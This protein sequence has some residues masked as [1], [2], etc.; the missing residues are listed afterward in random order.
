[1][2]RSGINRFR[3]LTLRE[4]A[5]GAGRSAAAVLVIAVSAAL[6]RRA[7]ELLDPVGS[8]D[9][10]VVMLTHDQ[11]AAERTDRIITLRDGRIHLP[12]AY[13]FLDDQTMD[14]GPQT[15]AF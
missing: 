5:A 3:V 14:T 7:T 6:L 13:R 8:A 4:I 15:E 10:A 12:S 2:I 11:Q 1:M 9:R